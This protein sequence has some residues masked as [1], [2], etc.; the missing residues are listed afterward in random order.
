MV[1]LGKR[2]EET[3][4]ANEQDKGVGVVGDNGDLRWRVCWNCVRVPIWLWTWRVVVDIERGWNAF[5]GGVGASVGCV[6]EYA[7]ILSDIGV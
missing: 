6:L 4:G 3:C 5:C 7:E 2:V 1:E